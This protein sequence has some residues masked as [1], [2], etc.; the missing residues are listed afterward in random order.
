MARRTQ[1]LKAKFNKKKLT[2]AEYQAE[3]KMEF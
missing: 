3:M 2:F 1:D